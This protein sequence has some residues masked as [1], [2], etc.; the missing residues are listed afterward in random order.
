VTAEI[1]TPDVEAILARHIVARAVYVA[2]VMILLFWLTRGSVG[3]WSAAFGVALVIGNFLLAGWILSI[4]ARVSLQVYHA[5]AI[6]GFFLRLGLLTLTMLVAVNLVPVDRLAFGITV[7]VAY[8]VL[9][10]AEMMAVV[11]GRERDLE[12][13]E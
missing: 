6:V 2:P 10:G 1:R 7:V 8:L 11:K 4:S 12:W 5:A 3:A 9:I 13:T